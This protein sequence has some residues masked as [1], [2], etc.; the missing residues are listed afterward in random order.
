ME[1]YRNRVLHSPNDTQTP[2]L[3]SLETCS[4]VILGFAQV[5]GWNPSCFQSVKRPEVVSSWEVNEAVGVART[6]SAYFGAL[7]CMLRLQ[8]HAADITVL[9]LKAPL[10]HPDPVV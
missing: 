9:S 2:S 4:L 1:G 10:A 8:V 3:R 6:Q 7:V 5:V